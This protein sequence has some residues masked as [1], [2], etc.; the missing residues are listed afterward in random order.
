VP[1]D[2]ERAASKKDQGRDGYKIKRR[3][4]PN[5]DQDYSS[6]TFNIYHATALSKRQR[7]VSGNTATGPRTTRSTTRQERIDAFDHEGSP[8][9]A[10]IANRGSD[11]LVG[12]K[13]RYTAFGGGGSAVRN[14]IR[15]RWKSLGPMGPAPP[16]LR[17]DAKSAARGKGNKD[18]K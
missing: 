5:G 13:E 8:A 15:A 6:S 10:T 9:S 7:S 4:Q 17:N 1:A 11:T 2:V 18:P 16:R 14:R 3:R 12:P